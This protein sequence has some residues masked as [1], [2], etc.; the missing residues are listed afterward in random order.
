MR[1]IFVKKNDNFFFQDYLMN[2]EFKRTAF[3]YIY[4]L[5]K[6]SFNTNKC[7]SKKYIY[8]LSVVYIHIFLTDTFVYIIH[9]CVCVYIYI[10]IYI[11]NYFYIYNLSKLQAIKPTN[12]IFFSHKTKLFFNYYSSTR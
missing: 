6:V 8:M 10:Y 7:V 11:Y 9:I 2:M 12:K 5:K 3:I 1:N 4:I